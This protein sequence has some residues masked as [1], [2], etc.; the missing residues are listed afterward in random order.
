MSKTPAQPLP[1]FDEISQLPDQ[2]SLYKD[3]ISGVPGGIGVVDVTIG[4]HCILVEAESGFGMSMVARGGAGSYRLDGVGPAM[5]LRS[6]ACL[7]TSWNF[8]EASVGVAALN[9]WYSTPEHAESVGMQV[10]EKGTNDGFDLYKGICT[11]KCVAVVGHFPMVERLGEYCDLTVLERNPYGDDVPD[12]ACEFVIPHSDVT[13]MTGLTL[14][15]KTMPRLLELSRAGSTILVGP[16]VIPAPVL[17]E[18]GVDCMGGSVIR[19]PE[20]AR[21]A[22][23]SG[24]ER[25]VFHNGV[26]KMRVERPG[27]LE[28][29]R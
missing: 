11:G 22:I 6:L 5:D 18:Y 20:R 21:H 19:D 17:Y 14:T 12:P 29:L 16:S 3:L 10:D 2:W 8:L 27:W 26:Q 13:F 9:A 1:T 24:L 28:S 4:L 23:T 7:S 25:G 15:N